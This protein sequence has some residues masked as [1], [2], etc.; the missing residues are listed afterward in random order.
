[1]RRT[2]L[3]LYPILSVVSQFIVA[4]LLGLALFPSALFLRWAW[5]AVGGLRAD[6]WGL[7]G[8][9]LALGFAFVLFGNSLLMLVIVL[10]RAFRIRATER[11]AQVF[12]FATIHYA[13]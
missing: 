2:L 9:C 11:R 1:M 5:T 7:L 6:V 10:S 13:L 8:L 3:W 4:L 12:S